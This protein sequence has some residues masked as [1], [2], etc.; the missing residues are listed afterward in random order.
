MREVVWADQ[1]TTTATIT[2]T[3]HRPSVMTSTTT[4]CGVRLSYGLDVDFD[5]LL[6]FP[7]LSCVKTTCVA[8]SIFILSCFS[9]CNTLI[10]CIVLFCQD[11]FKWQ[12]VSRA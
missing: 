9:L 11:I 3:P 10:T 12:S 8:L 2:T 4:D 5:R 7:V 1:T 6:D